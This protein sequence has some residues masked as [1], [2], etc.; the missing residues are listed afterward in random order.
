MTFLHLLFLPLFHPAAAAHC[1]SR[2]D[3]LLLL[4]C[5]CMRAESLQSCPALCDPM[6]C[7][8][9]SSVQGVLQARIL[10]WIAVPPPGDL[11]DPGVEPVSLVSPAFAG[12]FLVTSASWEALYCSSFSTIACPY[13]S[14]HCV[15][16]DFFPSS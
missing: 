8:P 11:P 2:Q 15:A 14:T 9:G 7:S 4:Y 3:S 10:D 6:D 16:R 12:R 13:S 5:S 1:F